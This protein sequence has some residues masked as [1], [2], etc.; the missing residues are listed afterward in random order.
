MKRIV[1]A[2]VVVVAVAALAQDPAK[3]APE[4]FKVVLENEQVRVIE[5]KAKAGEKTPMHS[6]PGHVIYPLAD[7]KTRFTFPDGSTR[8]LEIKKGVAQW[9]GPVTHA[10]VALTDNHV[11]VVEVK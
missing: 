3:V 1:G 2:F 11:F 8:D 7:G 6:H 5:F 4:H 10:H 9:V